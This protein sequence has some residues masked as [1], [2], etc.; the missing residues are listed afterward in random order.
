VFT[1]AGARALP[2]IGGALA[3]S[4]KTVQ[5]VSSALNIFCCEN[6]QNA[7]LLLR[8]ATEQALG[9]GAQRITR[10]RFVNTVVARMCQ[11]LTT[12]ACDL[13]PVT[14]TTDTVILAES[15]NLLPVD[16][17][18]TVEPRPA[19]AELKYFCSEEFK[20]WEQRKLFAHNGI[21][22][23]LAVLGKL[24]GYGY[25]YEAAEDTEIAT[26]VLGAM[27]NEVGAALTNEYPQWFSSANYDE[28]ARDLYGR[29]VSR[30]FADSIERG[31][32]NSLRMVQLD[33]GRL[34]GAAQFVAA[35][36][37][38]PCRLC[39]GVA[40]VL[41]VNAIPASDVHLALAPERSGLSEAIL[42]LVAKAYQAVSRWKDGQTGSLSDFT[43]HTTE[44][45]LI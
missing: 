8:E 44:R 32:R 21:H 41:H 28:F 29:I 17:D 1:A 10:L 34:S 15:Y 40:G 7:A 33:D 38:L 16:G 39:V 11:R 43:N 45:G 31:T 37:I 26:V 36:G 30:E 2:A 5:P 23:L 4:L 27:W 3:E 25:F 12:A 20:A 6:H 13:Q 14:P 22:A 9:E 24:R 42:D 19:I 35:H 18:A